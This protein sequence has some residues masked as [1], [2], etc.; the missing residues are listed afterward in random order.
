MTKM[1]LIS[2]RA[3][4]D[5]KTNE[6]VLWLTLYALPKKYI[7]K[8][9]KKEMLYYPKKDEALA[10]VRISF[11][12]RPDDYN[13]LLD[14]REGCICA[15]QYELNPLNNKPRIVTVDVLEGSAEYSFDFLYGY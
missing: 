8:S 11:Q 10:N 2:N 5:A 6:A 1:I 9:D 3:T 13:R 14:V 7:R 15:A 4:T 12:E